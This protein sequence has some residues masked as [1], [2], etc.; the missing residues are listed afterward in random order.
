MG[1]EKGV[2]TGTTIMAIEFDGGVIMAADSRTSMGDYIANRVS[3]ISLSI[4]S[5]RVLLQFVADA[6]AA[7][8]GAD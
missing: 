5:I 7:A 8:G 4:L 2:S 6:D 1:K 3:S